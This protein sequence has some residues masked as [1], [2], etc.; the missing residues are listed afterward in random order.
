MIWPFNPC[1]RHE[2][3]ISLLAVGALAEA[4]RAGLENHLAECAACR[5]KLA[6]LRTLAGA[7]DQL[8]RQLP[9]V[10]A[11]VAL[12]R[13]WQTAV[14]QAALHEPEPPIE[15]LPVWFCPRR[16]AWSSLAALWLLVAFFW[17]SAPNVSKQ[18]SVTAAPPSLREALL[19]L[20]V[21]TRESPPH[22]D[23]APPPRRQPASESAPP[24]SQR[25]NSPFGVGKEIA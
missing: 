24:R 18:A 12:R 16:L 14:R 7:V 2:A 15:T 10:E 3:G 8:G 1:R 5:A 9:S 19:A 11:P 23:A 17:L 22:E 4:E 21:E 25:R 13:R 6:G 20:K